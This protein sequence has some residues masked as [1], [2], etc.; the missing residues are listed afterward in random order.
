MKSYKI[1]SMSI[2]NIINEYIQVSIHFHLLLI[3]V[4]MVIN[5]ATKKI[6]RVY[7]VDKFVYKHK[8]IN[9]QP[10]GVLPEI[11]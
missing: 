3:I 7:F 9:L 5:Y 1:I 6:R 10:A 4:R 2:I 11:P 8:K